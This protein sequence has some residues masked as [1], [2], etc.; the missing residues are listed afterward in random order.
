MSLSVSWSAGPPLKPRLPKPSA[1]LR[2][3]ERDRNAAQ[4]ELD[5]AQ[6]AAQRHDAQAQAAQA[7]AGAAKLADSQLLVLQREPRVT[8]R[9]SWPKRNAQPKSSTR[10]APTTRPLPSAQQELERLGDVGVNETR[11]ASGSHC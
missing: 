11:C 6:A 8:P 1:T 4:A 2:E 5:Q 9:T 10:P 3:I 7:A